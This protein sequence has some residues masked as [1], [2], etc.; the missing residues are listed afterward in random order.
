MQSPLYTVSCN[1]DPGTLQFSAS[2]TIV[3]SLSKVATTFFQRAGPPSYVAWLK[4]PP[5]VSPTIE[6]G[7]VPNLK[8]GYGV[9]VT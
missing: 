3:V 6:S 1:G 9:M 5:H 7:G 4:K 2:A 8:G